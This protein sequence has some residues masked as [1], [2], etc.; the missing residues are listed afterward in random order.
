MLKT[1]KVDSVYTYHNSDRLCKLGGEGVVI[2]ENNIF[3][4]G[5]GKSSGWAV[6]W[7]TEATTLPSYS[8]CREVK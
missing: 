5:V 6:W 7:L 8:Y 3:V 1:F 4:S 2:I